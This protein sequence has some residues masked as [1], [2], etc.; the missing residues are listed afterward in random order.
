MGALY[1]KGFTEAE[2]RR[3]E[4]DLQRI[5]RNLEERLKS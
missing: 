5:Q 4:E 3:F 2:I 1:Y